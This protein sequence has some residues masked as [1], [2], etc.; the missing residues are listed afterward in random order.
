MIGGD[1]FVGEIGAVTQVESFEETW[2]IIDQYPTD[3]RDGV[4]GENAARIFNIQ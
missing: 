2:R 4:S 1:E 3:I